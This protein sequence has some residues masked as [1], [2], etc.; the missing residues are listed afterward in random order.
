ME[1][2]DGRII[3]IKHYFFENDALFMRATPLLTVP[4][5]HGQV[6]VKHLLVVQEESDELVAS[7]ALFKR[8]VIYVHIKDIGKAYVCIPPPLLDVK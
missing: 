5:Q 2:I 3:R 7:I 4:Y 6:K 1:L 8:K